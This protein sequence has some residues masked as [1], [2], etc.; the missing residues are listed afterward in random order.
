MGWYVVFKEGN[1][2]L[3]QIVPDRDEALLVACAVYLQGHLVHAVGPFGHDALSD[4]EIEG[5]QLLDILR[6]LL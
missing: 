3:T 4:H 6:K 2:T 5:D 1:E